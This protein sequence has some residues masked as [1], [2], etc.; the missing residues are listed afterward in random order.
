M[1]ATAAAGLAAGGYLL[2]LGHRWIRLHA[3]IRQSELDQHG[4]SERTRALPAG[5]RLIE[6]TAHHN[7]D[8]VIGGAAAGHPTR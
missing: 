7:V 6:K 1:A 8:I 5:S 4:L 3:Q 2:R